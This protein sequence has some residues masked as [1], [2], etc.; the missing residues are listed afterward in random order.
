[1]IYW[2]SI[3]I[4][5]AVVLV[6][7]EAKMRGKL[8]PH[9]FVRFLWILAL[10]FLIYD[11]VIMKSQSFSQASVMKLVFDR[12]DSVF[13]I[14][15]RKERSLQFAAEVQEW[16]R[17]QKQ[18][19]RFYSFAENL[20]EEVPSSSGGG[21]Q[22]HLGAALSDLSS[23]EGSTIVVSDGLWTDSVAEQKNVF[24]LQLGNRNEKDLWLTTPQNSLTAFLKNRLK[25]QVVVGQKGLNGEK[26]RLRLMKGL[27]TIDEKEVRLE[28][29]EQSVEF[30]YFPEKMG[31]NLLIVQVEA[32]ADELSALNNMQAIRVRT[33]RDKIRILHIGGKPSYDLKT[34]RQ[35]LTRQPDVDLVSFYILRSPND[36][37]QA[38]NN[39]LSLIPFPYEELFSSEL[40]KFDLVILQNFDFNLYFQPFYLANLANF[41]RAGGSLLVM[42]GDQ[43]LHRYR[44]S[45]L[46]PL[47]PFQYSGAANFDLNSDRLQLSKDHPITKDLE[48]S[49]SAL[50][51]SAIHSIQSKPEAEDLIRTSHGIPVLS[52]WNYDSG[53]VIVINS[54]EF[55][56]LQLA[57]NIEASS[58]GRM[59]RRIL[60][61]LTFDPEMEPTK[62][63]SGAWH[64]GQS[65]LLS[66]SELSDWKIIPLRHPDQVVEARNQNTIEYKIAEP[67]WY[68]VQNSKLSESKIYETVE[69][70]WIE[71]WRS[72]VSQSEPMNL[73]FGAQKV[74][75]FENRKQLLQQHLS[76]REIVSSR[77][78][79]WVRAHSEGA[80]LFL[81]ASLFLIFLDFFLRKKSR[82]DS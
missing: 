15:E 69:K 46:E 23:D 9:L 7:V 13:E 33:V 52:L 54:D 36:D 32:L 61:Y 71:E 47:F 20:R 73:A 25:L 67:G 78:E 62:M 51:L 56:K 27:E 44:F 43:S 72:F 79:P 18:P 76:G 50:N 70:P 5:F 60:Q 1:M 39:E 2:A 30:S 34:W 8:A 68:L 42:G 11:Y 45:P 37:P 16:A 64:V 80:W 6:A 63:R 58:F 38:R 22:T 74:F 40:P 48:A 53:R 41:V 12:S 4:A 29:A 57:P 26:V 55:W 21:M 3:F 82:W 10:G 49:V 59:A 14:P 81:L 28:K 17:E 24:G 75:S 19:I 31:E 77:H 35:F 65:V 66:S